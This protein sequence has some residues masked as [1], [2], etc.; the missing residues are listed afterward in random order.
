MIVTSLIT[1]CKTNCIKSLPFRN[2]W[3]KKAHFC[4]LLP[5]A[6]KIQSQLVFSPKWREIQK[7]KFATTIQPPL[8]GKEF[9]NREREIKAIKNILNGKPEFGIFSGPVNSGK[10]SLLLKI[11]EEESKNNNRPVLYI[12]LRERSFNT[13]QE[14][15]SSFEE[16]M[17]S[18]LSKFSEI[19]K[20]FKLKGY[21]FSLQASNAKNDTSPIEKV[22]N[23]F[24]MM[25]QQLPPHHS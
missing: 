11:L 2:F 5:T 16:E 21:G 12:D 19:A 22:N 23:L 24:K 18:W 4:S 10:T 17:S 7:R 9:F 1:G 8:T 6:K 20:R 25:S 13:V 3:S 14:F 15:A